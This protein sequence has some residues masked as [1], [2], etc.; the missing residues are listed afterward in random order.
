M[1]EAKPSLLL[2]LLQFPSVAVLFLWMIVPLGMTIY[3]SFIRKN[4]LNPEL[5]GFA[6]LENYRYLWEDPAFIPAIINS[7]ILIGAVLIITVVL[8]TLFAVL[9]DRDFFGKNVATLL[10]IA[11]FFVMPT[12]SALIWKNMMMHPVYGF[13]AVVMNKLGLPAIDWFSTHPLLSII[14]I[15]SW[16]WLPFAFLILFTSIKSLDQEQKEAA[17][18]DGANPV[19]FFFYVTLS[20]LSRAIGVVVMIETIFLLSIF[21][22][23]YTTT[24]GGPGTAT[25]NLAFLVYS[26][27]LQQFDAG[28][29]S[30]GGILAVVLANVVAFFMVRLMARNLQTR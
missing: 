19:Q 24:S 20:H 6:G 5:T 26:L 29:A 22:E 23:I 12:V 25:T 11:P 10:V 27:G 15:V 18:V 8:G 9:F 16:E 13:L 4:L 14:I 1:V 17:A 7:I 30:A 3:F 2:P 28:I 21:A